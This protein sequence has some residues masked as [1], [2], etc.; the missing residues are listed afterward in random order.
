MF[1]FFPGNP[2][3]AITETMA[4]HDEHYVKG[5]VLVLI[6]GCFWSIA[7]LV[8]RLMDDASE[9]QILF[10]RSLALVITLL[11]YI[12]LQTRGNLIGAFQ[13]AGLYAVLAGAFLSIAFTCWIFAMTHT[14]IAN[15]LFVLSAAPFLAA[16]FARVFIG[17]L[18]KPT[19]WL[20]MLL[21]SLGV[22]VMVVEGIALGT[23]MGNL[24]ALAAAT[25]FAAFSVILRKGKSVDMTPAVCWAGIWGAL[26]AAF[27]LFATQQGF[28]LST[29]D[30]VLC[31]LLG[32][33]Q[34]GLGLI[35]FTAGSRYVPAAEITLLSLTEVVLGPIWVW[36]GVN[37]IPSRLTL[38]GG[39][40]VLI[41]IVA[42]AIH[43]TRKKRPPVGVV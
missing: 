41:A 33:V 39:A 12:G 38:I 22:A 16:I 25:G 26:I 21:A 27:M 18:V 35:L 5:V 3:V 23:L 11:I 14:T 34:V 24:F 30:L 32:F 17:E 40:I 10:Y 31:G 19:T 36:L 2:P 28:V 1:H 4:T 13:R 43:G 20:Y 37:E 15:A 7:G 6:A 42:Q 8:V 29:H 9:W